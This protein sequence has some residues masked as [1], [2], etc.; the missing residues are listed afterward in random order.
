MVNQLNEK[1]EN[2]MAKLAAIPEN[3]LDFVNY[4]RYFNVAGT[5]IDNLITEIDFAYQCFTIMDEYNIFI[6]DLEKE[7][8]MGKENII[9]V[10]ACNILFC[11]F[12]L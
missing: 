10:F 9:I 2:I 1:A 11:F 8:Y 5:Q 3:T 12:F 6:D 4:M 7:A